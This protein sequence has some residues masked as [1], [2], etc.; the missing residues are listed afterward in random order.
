MKSLGKLSAVSFQ[1]SAKGY[2]SPPLR[3]GKCH[4][5]PATESRATWSCK[6]VIR[7]ARG[8]FRAREL[9]RFGFR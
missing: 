4:H 5:N 6:A 7:L 3:G 2:R 8:R 1:L 9:A